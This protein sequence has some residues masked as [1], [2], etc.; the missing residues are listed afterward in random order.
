MAYHDTRHSGNYCHDH[1]SSLCSAESSF[2]T[3]AKSRLGVDIIDWL[4]FTFTWPTRSIDSTGV[5]SVDRLDSAENRSTR[6]T[7]SIDFKVYYIRYT[8]FTCTNMNRKCSIT[9]NKIITKLLV[10]WLI[11]QQISLIK[12]RHHF[13]KSCISWRCK[14]T[15]NHFIS[16]NTM[17]Y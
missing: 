11:K 12:N 16:T 8:H 1:C 13:I 17:H 5:D 6:S 14:T 10:K 4:D 15:K 3:T 9:N 7:D 2:C